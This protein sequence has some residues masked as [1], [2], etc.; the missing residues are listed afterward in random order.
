METFPLISTPTHL[1]KLPVRVSTQAVRD[2]AY[3]HFHQQLQLCFVLSGEIRQTVNGIEYLQK[4]GSCAFLLPYTP[5]SFDAHNSEDTPI[6]A[7]IW[8]E[9][10]F[11]TSRGYDIYTYGKKAAH[12][13]KKAIPDV[14]DFAEK[15]EISKR[16]VRNLIAEFD[17][18][19]DMSFDVLAALTAE[20][21]SIACKE[22]KKVKITAPFRRQT[23]GIKLATDYIEKNFAKKLSLDE[24]CKIAGTS[25]RSFTAN[26][27]AV[28]G[29]TPNDYILSTRISH[30]S[31]LLHS[32]EMLYEDIAKES[33]LYNHSNLARV[34]LRV[35]GETPTEHRERRISE[36]KSLKSAKPLSRFDWIYDI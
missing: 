31:F 13:E 15:E 20:L 3:L 24:L 34:F 32:T 7:H 33:G 29:V 30:A 2:S 21:F 9:Q 4:S 18:R 11:L 36:N 23:E 5:H 1:S 6:I 25:R 22:E 28:T 12:F 17:K 35:L 14:F 10:D 26:F 16:I 27:K 19:A 8:F